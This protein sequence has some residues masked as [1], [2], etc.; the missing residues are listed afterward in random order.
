[1]HA[2][3]GHCS[4]CTMRARRLSLQFSSQAARESDSHIPATASW[5]WTWTA[6]CTWYTCGWRFHSPSFTYSAL[7]CCVCYIAFIKCMIELFWHHPDRNMSSSSKKHW[8]RAVNIVNSIGWNLFLCPM[9]G[10]DL[11]YAVATSPSKNRRTRHT[12]SSRRSGRRAF[13]DGG[14]VLC[15]A[16][17]VLYWWRKKDSER[18][19]PSLT[20]HRPACTWCYLHNPANLHCGPGCCRDLYNQWRQNV[21]NVCA[22][23]PRHVPT[24]F[25]GF[26]YFASW[27]CHEAQTIVLQMQLNAKR[28]CNFWFSIKLSKKNVIAKG[29]L[30]RT[31]IV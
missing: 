14:S 20:G 15:L 2:Q 23:R 12:P 26:K 16:C 21:T 19:D 5:N 29:T 10:S 28:V 25:G 1:M 27:S 13:L 6:G 8:A 17:G 18:Y 24:F 4:C 7:I 3:Q 11:R 9:L 22:T 31:L 30:K